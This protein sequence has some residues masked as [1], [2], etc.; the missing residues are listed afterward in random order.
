MVSDADISIDLPVF[1]FH[2][3]S[4]LAD[5]LEK[6]FIPGTLAKYPGGFA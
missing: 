3:I 6:K 2:E 5:F 1:R 4:K